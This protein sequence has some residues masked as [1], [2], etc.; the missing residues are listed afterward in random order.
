MGLASNTFAIG[1]QLTCKRGETTLVWDIIGIDHDT[2]TDNNFK[3]SLTLQ[4]HDCLLSIQ[5]DGTEA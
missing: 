4:L 3:H 1:D 5:Y 2:P